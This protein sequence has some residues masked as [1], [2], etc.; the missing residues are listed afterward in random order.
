MK[1]ILSSLISLVVAVGASAQTT[2]TEY[3]LPAPLPGGIGGATNLYN[4]GTRVYA[5]TFDTSATP[6]AASNLL[7]ALYDSPKTNPRGAGTIDNILTYTNSGYTTYTA[8]TSNMNWLAAGSQPIQGVNSNVNFAGV[9]STITNSA[10]LSN[11]MFT[12]S[13]YVSGANY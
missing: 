1:K 9:T 10:A 13:N 6:T 5:V 11:Y 2:T 12:V 8:Y 3:T 4:G 7:W